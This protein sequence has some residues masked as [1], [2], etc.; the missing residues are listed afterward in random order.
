MVNQPSPAERPERGAGSGLP[1]YVRALGLDTTPF[2][3]TPDE[4]RYFFTARTE[5][6]Y[7]E[8]LHFIE[9]RRGFMLLTG[10]IGLGKTTLLRRILGALDAER[11]N[12][13]LVLSSFLNQAELLEA[14]TRDFGL[15]PPAGASRYEHL[16]ALNAFL[17]E[18]AGAGKINVLLIDDA[19][20]LDAQALDLVRQLGNL[21]TA[22]Q[23]LIQ[24]VL[25]GQSEILATLERHDL[26][27]VRS[28]I[29]LHREVAPLTAAELADYL[30]HR[31][32]LAG[33]A[34]AVRLDAGALRA[35]ERRGGGYPR[36]VHHLMDRCLYALMA[37]PGRTSIDAALVELAWSDLAL[38]S[39]ALAAP[40]APE[41]GR[42]RLRIALAA[43]LG[44]ALL[45][46]GYWFGAAAPVRPV[47]L[48]P[49]KA[50]AI[51]AIPAAAAAPARAAI[52]APAG[53]PAR[54][55][56]GLPPL[57]WPD[58]G[59]FAALA[60]QLDAAARRAGW[61][62]QDVAAD[63]A[64][65]CARRPLWQVSDAQGGRRHFTLIEAEWPTRPLEMGRYDAAVEAAQRQLIAGGWLLQA[66][67]DGVMGARTGVALARFQAANQIERT[68]QF[69]PA[70]AYR[71]S[72]HKA[73]AGAGA[74]AGA[75]AAAAAEA[76]HG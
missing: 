52:A 35:I 32:A 44:L 1:P 66:E 53:W 33:N 72:C 6:I 65:P 17:L 56:T 58:S 62:V 46:G 36:R 38:P 26:R 31:L 29:A 19:Q 3:V 57:A 2:P 28:R 43:A 13:A 48:A 61:A 39:A 75:A 68:G 8:L 30:R 69:N 14:I 10:D 27:Q 16:L 4:T 24:V 63:F 37:R 51:S 74:G 49:L 21:E 70:T 12:T 7:H 25:V 73:G 40:G 50:A 22:D 60:G 41:R 42:G 20:A 5:A 59:D 45:G 67:T 64:P 76:R 11:F 15:T 23:K 34:D 71:L 18:Q 55:A 9:T 54:P 47:A